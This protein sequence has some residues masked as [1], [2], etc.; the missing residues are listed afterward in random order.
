MT[1]A[2]SSA[3][4]PARIGA[5]LALCRV[6]NLPTVWM[7][8]LAAAV[9]AGA[10]ARTGTVLLL[11]ASMSAFYCGGMCLNDICDRESDAREQPFRPIPSGRVTVGGAWVA[12]CVLFAAG[13]GLL[14]LAPYPSAL[15]PGLLLLGTIIAYDRRHKQNAASVLLMAACRLLVFAICAWAVSGT[16]R[17]LVLGAGGVC[18]AYTLGISLA[19]RHEN[20]R[21]A[22]YPFPLIP[23]L[24]AGMAVVDGLYLAVAVAPGWMAAGVAAAG[25]TR[26]GQRYVRGD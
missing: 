10:G 15:V 7:N 18:F 9:L 22:P 17:P 8:A 6:S 3:P 20:R 23:N 16:V 24:I 14:A 5:L 12:T 4:G 21:G 1:E 19:A 26:F 13:L 25:L 2:S 11:A